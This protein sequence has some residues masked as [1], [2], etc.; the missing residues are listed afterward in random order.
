[1]SAAVP[2]KLLA[3][4]FRWRIVV[5]FDNHRV[6]TLGQQGISPNRFGHVRDS[7]CDRRVLHKRSS[8]SVF[9]VI[10]SDDAVTKQYPVLRSE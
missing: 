9:A 8:P 7:L 4:G 1:M 3:D 2:E 10:L 5:S 6:V